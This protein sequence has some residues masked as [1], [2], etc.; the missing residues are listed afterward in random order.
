MKII[1]FYISFMSAFLAGIVTVLWIGSHLEAPA[2]VG[3]A[4]TMEIDPQSLAD[5]TCETDPAWTESSI[6]TIVQSGKF[7]DVVFTDDGQTTLSGGIDEL[8]I[9]AQLPSSRRNAD[10]NLSMGQ[11]TR[12]QADVDRQEVPNRLSGSIEIAGCAEALPFTA[13]RQA[14]SATEVEG[15]AE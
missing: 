15:G 6:L 4:W 14:V 8:T 11:P 5:V 12:L 9:T 10:S 3:G 1:L 2:A 7:I 13:A